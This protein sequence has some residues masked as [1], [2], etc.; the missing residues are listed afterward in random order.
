MV[1]Y[2]KQNLP[3]VTFSTHCATLTTVIRE[4]LY[5]LEGSSL[6]LG[7]T[8]Q[9]LPYPP[10]PGS[11]RFAFQWPWRAVPSGR[12]GCVPMVLGGGPPDVRGCVCA[13]WCV[14]V[15]PLQERPVGY[16]AS[17]PPYKCPALSG[18]K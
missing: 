1:K 16:R 9:M 14:A 3:L 10:A 6:P 13:S 7:L 17:V 5:T 8:P 18:W 11:R 15:G 12:M 2:I 4:H